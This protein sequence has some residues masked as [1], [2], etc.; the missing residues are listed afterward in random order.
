MTVLQEAQGFSRTKSS[1]RL[2]YDYKD[3]SQES[4]SPEGSPKK[5][6]DVS[7]VAGSS[8]KAEKNTTSSKPITSRPTSAKTSSIGSPS[9]S[10]RFNENVSKTP[11]K[12]DTNSSVSSSRLMSRY[13]FNGSPKGPMK[14]SPGSVLS[15]ASM[16]EKNNSTYVKV[17]DPAEMTLSERMA[18]FERNK[19]EALIPKAPL[20]MS[21]PTKKLMEKEKTTAGN[22]NSRF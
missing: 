7:E 2:V 9:G 21:V 8:Q 20:T 18:L 14:Q 19:G 11:E 4:T 13:G 22:F 12:I 5:Q 15:K 6:E 17:K 1:S 3:C 10:S 16:F